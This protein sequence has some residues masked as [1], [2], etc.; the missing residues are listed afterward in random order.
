M[1]CGERCWCGSKCERSEGHPGGEHLCNDH[2]P[3][4]G[5]FEP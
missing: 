1:I 4:I 2:A 3:R 5:R